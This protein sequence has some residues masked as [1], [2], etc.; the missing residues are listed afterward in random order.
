MAETLADMRTR[1]KILVG[2][3]SGMDDHIDDN[4]NEAVLQLLQ[5]VM[6]QEVWTDT[7]FSLT[8]STAEYTF[9]SSPISKTDVWC[10]V[11]MRNTTDDEEIPRGGPRHYNRLGQDTSDASNLGKPTRW[12][13]IGNKLV[14]YNKIPD[15]TSRTVKLT[16]IARP[17]TMDASN[18]FPLN[19]EWR[20]P[21]EALAAALT[22]THLNDMQK[23]SLHM[24]SYR[25]LITLRQKPEEKEDEAPEAQ[26]VPEVWEY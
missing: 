14:I 26:L 13:R 22:W 4:I 3:K 12:T 2:N 24:S 6:P 5:E 21:V 11:M 20:K 16:Y 19:E 23:A 10:V 18:D 17:T 15:S 8:A 25:E 1:V 9:S 7:S